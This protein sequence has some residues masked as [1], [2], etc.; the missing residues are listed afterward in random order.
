MTSV[1][2]YFD[3]PWLL[4]AV[5]LL[6]LVL[7]GGVAVYARRRRERLAR[8]GGDSLVGRLTDVPLTQPMHW[9]ALRLAL[10]GACI[11]VAL[12]GPRWGVERSVI[13]GE[14]IDLVLALDASLSMMATDERPNRLERMKQEVRRLRALSPHDRVALLAFAGRSYI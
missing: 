3:Y 13:R 10:A 6:P 1:L 8:L 5:L 12:A 14:G 9:R 4:A 2:R 11:A 7:A